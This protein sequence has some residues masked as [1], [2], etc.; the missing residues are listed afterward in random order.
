MLLAGDVGGTKTILALY[1]QIDSDW[2]C[3][4]KER[5]ASADFDSFNKLLDFFLST[6]ADQLQGVCIGVAGPVVNGD[7]VTTNLPWVLKTKEI[8]QQTGAKHV[9]LL[10]DLEATAWGVLELPVSDFVELNPDAKIN[11]GNLAVLA[12]GTGLG[13]ALLVWGDDKYHVAATEGGHTDFAPRNELEIGLLRYLMGLHPE[14]V[15]NERVVCGQG[16]VNIYQYLKSIQYAQV[17]DDDEYRMSQEDPAAVISEKG[18][19]TTNELCV[20]ALDMFC[21]IYGA[22]AGNLV[23]KS[24]PKAG[25]VLAGGIA[26]KILPSMQKGDFM[27]GYLAKGR[28]KAVLQDIPVKV[29]LNSEVALIG[30]IT[31]ARKISQ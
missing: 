9:R 15:S 11:K 21:E 28:Y 6:E 1:K 30:A 27:R 3:H 24:L 20:K 25:V 18:M 10:N 23:L 8:S 17:D 31:V 29:C 16:L 4:K 5:F 19:N 14:H 2:V 12:A 7:C 26:A 13:E 22:E